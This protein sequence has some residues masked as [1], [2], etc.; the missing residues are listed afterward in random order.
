MRMYCD[1]QH[2]KSNQDGLITYLDVVNLDRGKHLLE[3]VYNR[4]DDEKS[5]F[6]P[7]VM[8]KVEFYKVR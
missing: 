4:W 1:T 5:E 8:A 7:R 3:L 6:K 2:Q